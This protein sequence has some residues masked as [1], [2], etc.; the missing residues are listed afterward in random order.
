MT[1]DHQTLT[2]EH[3][4]TLFSR[5]DTSQKDINSQAA[6]GRF[7]VH[8]RVSLQLDSKVKEHKA[9]MESGYELRSQQVARNPKKGQRQTRLCTGRQ[10]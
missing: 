7:R 2:T 10:I 1:V 9:A 3:G 5:Q 4:N 8:V 6:R